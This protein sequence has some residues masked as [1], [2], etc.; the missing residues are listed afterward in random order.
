MG[1]LRESILLNKTMYLQI[2]NTRSRKRKQTKKNTFGA[3]IP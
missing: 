2:E 3:K 1:D